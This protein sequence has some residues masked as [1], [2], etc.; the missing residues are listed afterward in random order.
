MQ[1]SE[2]CD[3]EL[4]ARNLMKRLFL[5]LLTGLISTAVW[6]QNWRYDEENELYFNCELIASL[7]ADF[8][9]EDIL[10][11]ADDDLMTLTDFFDWSFSTCAE[12]DRGGR[13]RG[14]RRHG[15]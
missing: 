6:A 1:A 9:E 12:M 14:V 11:F 5:I 10:K 13:G 7:K 2:V 8:G 4:G 3:I 15:G